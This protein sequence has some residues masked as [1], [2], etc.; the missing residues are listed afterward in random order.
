MARYPDTITVQEL[1]TRYCKTQAAN[2][3]MTLQ[4]LAQ[5]EAHHGVA[6][7]VL[8]ECVMLDSSKMGERTILP[9]GPGCTL[10]TVPDQPMSPRGL[11]SDM[12]VVI[13]VAPNP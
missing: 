8:L 6:G 13:A 10:K 12:S 9:Y 2:P 11:A 3:K 4:R 7:W 1:I 5:I